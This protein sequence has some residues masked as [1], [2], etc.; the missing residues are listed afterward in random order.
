MVAR[1][2]TRR[3]E[4]GQRSL[5]LR[6]SSILRADDVI[7]VGPDAGA[8]GDEARRQGKVCDEKAA[9]EL[10]GAIFEPACG[11]DSAAAAALRILRLLS[12][13]L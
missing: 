8:D 6:S 2:R 7:C 3:G 11:R 12:D 13:V 4:G 5:S 10:V 9:E 1:E